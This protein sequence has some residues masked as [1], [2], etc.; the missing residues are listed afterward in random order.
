MLTDADVAYIRAEFVPLADLCAA[1][2]RDLEEV[3]AAIAARRL[4]APPYPGIEYVP[5]NYFQ[6]P[7]AATF[8]RTFAGEN[9]DEELEGYLDGTYFVCLREASIENISRKGKLVDEIRELRNDP[10]PDD[11][12]WRMHLHA[13]VDELDELERPFSPDFDRIRFA[14]PPPTRD[15][16]IEETRRLF[17]RD[18]AA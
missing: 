1:A 7:D 5:A 16:L 2:S 3:R 8:R 9:L 10:Q 12:A 11:P 17:P 13:L 15:E 6:L 14:D 4:P 18:A